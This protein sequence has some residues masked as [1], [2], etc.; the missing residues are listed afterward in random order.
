MFATV[1]RNRRTRRFGFTL[2][3]LLVVMSV[4]AIL[5]ALLVPVLG[6]VRKQMHIAAV[7]SM[8]KGITTAI[9]TYKSV[10]MSYPPDKHPDYPGLVSS[11]C[12]IYY[13]SGPTIFYD[14]DYSPVDYPWKHDLYNVASNMPGKGRKNFQRYYDF[15][16]KYLQDYGGHEAPALV[17]PWSRRLIYNATGTASA[18]YGRYGGAKHGGKE[19]DLF[20]AGPDGR[21]GTEDDVTNWQDKLG[22]GYDSFNLNNGTH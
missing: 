9:T 5:A 10:H 4:I 17:D 13:L 3:E 18:Y 6:E 14:V 16:S 19:Y 1:A 21:F 22:W 7:G 15:K 11:Q 12:L 8:I 20:S 2:I